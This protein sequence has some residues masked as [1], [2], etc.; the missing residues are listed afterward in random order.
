MWNNNNNDISATEQKKASVSFLSALFLYFLVHKISWGCR[1]VLLMPV[2]TYWVI[3]YKQFVL[4]MQQYYQPFL[5]EDLVFLFI[6]VHKMSL[7]EKGQGFLFF[8][9]THPPNLTFGMRRLFLLNYEEIWVILKLAHK[10]SLKI[11]PT[12]SFIL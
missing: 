10:I 5:E 3:D 7:L 2:E 6:S 11:F 12:N 8:S 1:L 4:K 9:L